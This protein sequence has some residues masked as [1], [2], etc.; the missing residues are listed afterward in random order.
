M[1]TVLIIAL[2]AGLSGCAMASSVMDAGNGA[3]LISAAASPIRGGAAGAREVA[4]DGAQKYCA[5]KPGGVH[6]IVLDTNDH[7]V[8]QGSIVNGGVYAAGN[9]NLR[10]RCG[11]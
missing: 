5:T 1:K 4:Y 8:Y 11:E 7:D 9:A 10:F 6:A 2:A 3:Y